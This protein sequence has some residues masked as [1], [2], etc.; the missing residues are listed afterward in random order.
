MRN[1]SNQDIISTKNTS[2]ILS[3]ILINAHENRLSI[4]ATDLKVNFETEV[5]VQVSE[6]GSTTIYCDKFLSILNTCPSGETEI[7]DKS[8]NSQTKNSKIKNNN[9]LSHRPRHF[10]LIQSRRV[11]VDHSPRENSIRCQFPHSEQ[12]SCDNISLCCFVSGKKLR[13]KH[14][15]QRGA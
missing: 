11:Q 1:T 10:I 3:N 8:I 15:M 4:K 7:C 6:E 5:P 2:S 14:T 9:A 13:N 12:S